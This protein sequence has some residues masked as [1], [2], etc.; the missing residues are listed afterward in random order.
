MEAMNPIFFRWYGAESPQQTQKPVFIVSLKK[1]K[2]NI[3]RRD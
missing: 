3:T 1:G 2:M